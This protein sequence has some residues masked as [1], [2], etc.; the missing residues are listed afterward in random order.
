MTMKCA[1]PQFYLLTTALTPTQFTQIGYRQSLIK[2]TAPKANNYS[3]DYY[4]HNII[5]PNEDIFLSN[6]PFANP[7]LTENFF[8]KTPY[9]FTLSTLNKKNDNVLSAALHGINAYDSKFNKFKNFSQTFHFLT[10]KERDLHCSHDV[11][12]RTKQTHTYTYYQFIQHQYNLNTPARQSH[13]RYQY[14]NSAYTSPFFLNIT[15]CIKDTN[16]QGT[17]RNYD[18]ITQMYIFCP[19]TKLLNVDESRPLIV[20]HEFLHPVDVPMLEFR[21]NT[22]YNH[23]LY[24]LIQN[25]P[26]ELSTSTEEHNITKALELLGPLLQIKHIIRLLAKLLTSSDIIHDVFPHA[27]FTVD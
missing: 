18:H 15:Y 20:P 17:L 5:R 22:R 16:L 19:L 12:L 10:P 7:Q 24:N 1:A 27:F 6:E 11:M 3:I 8:I 23:K 21:Y 26:Y 25:R 9:N 14:I 4:D 13:H 2:F